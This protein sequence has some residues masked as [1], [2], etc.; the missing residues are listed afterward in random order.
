MDLPPILPAREIPLS[1]KRPPFTIVETAI[2]DSEQ[3]TSSEKRVYIAL[4]SFRRNSPP[5]QCKPGQEKIMR[6]AGVDKKTYLKARDKLKIYGLIK[7]EPSRSEKIGAGP[8]R[9]KTI[10]YIF[11]LEPE[12]GTD[13]E[14][15]RLLAF[16]KVKKNGTKQNRFR[17]KKTVENDTVLREK[18]GIDLHQKTVENDTTIKKVLTRSN[19]EQQQEKTKKSDAVA[20][21]LNQKEEKPKLVVK[22]N[23]RTASLI[24]KLKKVGIIEDKAVELLATH[25]YENVEKQVEWLPYREGI[26]H[27]AG[28]LIRAI[29]QSWPEPETRGTGVKRRTEESLK[30]KRCYAGYWEDQKAMLKI[31]KEDLKKGAGPER[32]KEWLDKLDPEYHEELKKFVRKLNK[33]KGVYE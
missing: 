10:N 28:A 24:T 18:N 1:K 22:D 23:D 11:P 21:S 29:E 15:K 12:D 27:P 3:L 19:K 14:I 20:S 4:K 13:E 2:I 16:L 9:G 30:Y 17:R 33:Y 7:F 32:V 8:G 26:K 5:T 25:L 31:A 6:R